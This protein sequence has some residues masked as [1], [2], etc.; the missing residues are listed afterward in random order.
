MADYCTLFSDGIS[1]ITPEEEKWIARVLKNMNDVEVELPDDAD[2]ND[3]DSWPH[4][5]WL[6]GELG[7]VMAEQVD[8]WPNFEWEFENTPKGRN[9][10]IYSDYSGDVE[11]VGFFVSAYLTKF[12]PELYWSME[13]AFTCTKPIIGAF[14]GGG[15]FVTADEVKWFSPWAQIEAEKKKMEAQ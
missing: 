3:M 12:H 7:L 15:I 13:Y 1:D 10:W 2:Q 14:G 4:V 8:Y 11:H 6:L 9:L 5:E